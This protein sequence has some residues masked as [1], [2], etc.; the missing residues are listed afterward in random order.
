MIRKN[1]KDNLLHILLNLAHIVR[2]V[3]YKNYNIIYFPI[4]NIIIQSNFPIHKDIIWIIFFNEN[5]HQQV[6]SF[7]L[8]HKHFTIN[9]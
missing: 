6:E 4:Y 8:Y 3:F 1:E 7:I 9:R 5:L 2:F